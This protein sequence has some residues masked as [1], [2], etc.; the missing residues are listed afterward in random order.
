[1]ISPFTFCCLV[2]EFLLFPWLFRGIGYTDIRFHGGMLHSLLA[3]CFLLFQLL[4]KQ[5]GRYFGEAPTYLIDTQMAARE[6]K[7]GIWSI[8]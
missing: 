3:V 8:A 4:A 7:V 5:Q 1:M 6:N 2:G